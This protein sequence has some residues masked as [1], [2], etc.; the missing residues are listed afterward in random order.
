MADEW[1]WLNNILV[2]DM[3]ARSKTLGDDNISERF[4]EG[5]KHSARFS[6]TFARDASCS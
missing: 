3:E 6:G 5:A 4:V 2:E 1:N